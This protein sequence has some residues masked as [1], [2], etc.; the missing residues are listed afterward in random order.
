MGSTKTWW[1]LPPQLVAESER[2]VKAVAA[3]QG[4]KTVKRQ[5]RDA[6][7]DLGLGY[8]TVWN[9][10]RGKIG[11]RAFPELLDAYTRW[12]DRQ[13]GRELETLRA[14]I[15]RLEQNGDLASGLG[16]KPP[17]GP[18]LHHARVKGCPAD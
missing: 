12:L 14:R 17:I 2:M 3:A 18:R 13:T 9:A 11:S 7:A 5:I 15:E 1:A 10:W 6:A 4:G 16:G 8:W